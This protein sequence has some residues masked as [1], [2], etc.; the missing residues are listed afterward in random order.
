[1]RSVHKVL[2]HAKIRKGDILYD[3]GAGDGRFLNI[4]EK[5]YGAHAIGYEMDPG[6]YLYAKLKQW[7]LGWKGTMIRSKFQKHKI[8][9]ADIIVCYMM[10]HT[11]KK[12]EKFFE[13][14]I[15]SGTRVISYAFKIGDLK[16]KK[17]I[18]SDPKNRISKIS[19]YEI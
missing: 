16:A 10:P 11:L 6:V 13:K 3:L 1:M 7:I 15:A 18:P 8:T 19:I 4:A 17:I 14:Q 5:E 12:L 9:N 2:K